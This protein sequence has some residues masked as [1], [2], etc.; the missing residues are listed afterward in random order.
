MLCSPLD[1]GSIEKLLE[2]LLSKKPNLEVFL[3]QFIVPEDNS[4]S[5]ALKNQCEEILDVVCNEVAATDSETRVGDQGAG[6]KQGKAKGKFKKR[7][8][9]RKK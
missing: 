2:S 1:R 5:V 9:N 4:W 7:K 3:N 8:G 6:K